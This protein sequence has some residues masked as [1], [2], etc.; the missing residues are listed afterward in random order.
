MCKTVFSL[1]LS[2]SCVTGFVMA[3]ANG[4]IKGNDN[5]IL[6]AYFSRAGNIDMSGSVDATTAAS[7]NL[8]NGKYV[9]NAELMAQWIQEEVGGDL[10][11]I[12][13]VEPYSANYDETVKRVEDENRRNIHPALSSHVVNMQE[14]HIIFLVYPIWA[15]DLPVAM[16]TFLEE[17]DLSGKTIIPI[18]TS[19][20]TSI[21]RT[22]ETIKRM[23][24]EAKVLEGIT[25]NHNQVLR[26]KNTVISWLKKI[27]IVK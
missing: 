21:S 12:K 2:F 5:S 4:E 11:F 22:I 17:Y 3:Q 16:Y 18:C 14:Y 25:V 23:E 27:E 7:V 6:I 15:Y 26:S 13:T 10:F 1:L 9:G 24:P 20:A 19:G 8:L